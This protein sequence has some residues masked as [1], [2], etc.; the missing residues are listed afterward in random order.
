MHNGKIEK[1]I[2]NYNFF[3]LLLTL[4]CHFTYY[5]GHFYLV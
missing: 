5:F 4:W 1:W 3:K 2:P